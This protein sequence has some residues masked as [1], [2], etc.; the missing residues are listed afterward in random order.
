MPC[1]AFEAAFETN[2][3]PTCQPDRKMR[4]QRARC[5]PQDYSCEKDTTP[6]A[7]APFTDS[8]TGDRRKMKRRF[9]GDRPK[10]SQSSACPP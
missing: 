10:S 7:I 6:S 2:L 1:A 8:A 5:R 4:P 9:E 3:Q